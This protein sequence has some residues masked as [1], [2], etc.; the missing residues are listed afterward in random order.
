[1]GEF[2]TMMFPAA[3]QLISNLKQNF[4]GE[5]DIKAAFK[6]W[7]S[8]GDGEIS[9]KELQSAVQRSGQKLSEEDI[10]A[11]FVV[12][13]ADQNGSIDLQEFMAMMR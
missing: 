8:D 4:R 12:G 11:I 5:S 1:M 9:F 13:D 3:G 10:N 6:S 2:V 7:D